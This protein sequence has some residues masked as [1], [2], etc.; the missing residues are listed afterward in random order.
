MANDEAMVITARS[1]GAR[2]SYDKPLARFEMWYH[3]WIRG[4]N[5]PPQGSVTISWNNCGTI[6][7]EREKGSGCDNEAAVF[8]RVRGSERDRHVELKHPGETEGRAGGTET[9]RG[10]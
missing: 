7:N 9:R 1:I 4:H 6:R 8:F 3:G 2:T 10:G 5:A